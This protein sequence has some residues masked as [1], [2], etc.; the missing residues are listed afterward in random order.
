MSLNKKIRL[1]KVY[2]QQGYLS[3]FCENIF[4][5]MNFEE[6]PAFKDMP[7]RMAYETEIWMIGEQIRQEIAS[8]KR[9]KISPL[10]LNEILTVINTTKYGKGRESFVMTLH[11]FRNNPIVESNLRNLLDDKQLYGFAIKE[12]NKLKSYHL[13]NKIEDILAQEKT[14]WIKKEAKLYIKNSSLSNNVSD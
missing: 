8:S 2:T 6:E 1:S 7:K 13:I 11:Y 3:E 9:D 4:N 14:A 5:N 10:L 12:L